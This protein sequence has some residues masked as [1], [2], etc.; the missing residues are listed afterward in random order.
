MSF[1]FVWVIGI[2]NFR[3][4]E[5]SLRW[6]YNN[7]QCKN[8]KLSPQLT[9]RIIP[10]EVAAYSIRNDGAFILS[11]RR[12]VGARKIIDAQGNHYASGGRA[13][14]SCSPLQA[15]VTL[16]L[17]GL[18]IV[19]DEDLQR[20]ILQTDNVLVAG[21]KAKGSGFPFELQF[22]ANDLIEIVK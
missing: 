20:C 11:D 14:L 10:E 19:K 4:T 16:S 7:G 5:I 22:L 1:F 13:F 9:W 8:F 6:K 15:G 18:Q 3:K 21:F 12:S 17:L 2:E